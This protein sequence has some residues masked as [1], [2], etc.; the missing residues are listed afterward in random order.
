M[1]TKGLQSDKSMMIKMQDVFNHSFVENTFFLTK[2]VNMAQVQISQQTLSK[3]DLPDNAKEVMQDKAVEKDYTLMLPKQDQYLFSQ[4][5]KMPESDS[6]QQT[7]FL[8]DYER[9]VNWKMEQVRNDSEFGIIHVPIQKDKND[10]D[11][12]VDWEK[13]EEDNF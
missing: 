3:I 5:F 7:A 11:A 10:K 9:F 6:Y 4:I 13:I 1:R 8:N 2:V 12:K